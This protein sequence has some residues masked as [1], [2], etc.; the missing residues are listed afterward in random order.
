[1]NTVVSTSGLF[2]AESQYLPVVISSP[3]VILRATDELP[4]SWDNVV[5]PVDKPAGWTSFDIIRRLR[6][7]TRLRRIGH[8]GT[9]DPMATG[10]LICL[11]GK[12]TRQMTKWLEAPKT[13]TGAMRLGETTASYD[14]DTEVLETRDWRHITSEDLERAKSQ[15]IGEIVQLP[16]MYSAVKVGGERLYKKARRG[17]SIERPPRHVS[18]YSFDITDVRGQDVSFVIRCSKGTYIRS[19]AHDFGQR[20][21]VGAHL[22]ALRRTAIGDLDVRDAW[23][24]D[25]LER[26]LPS[27]DSPGPS[28]R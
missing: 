9:L 1:M 19:L 23:T 7:L 11:L 24:I 13:Y 4:G 8:A 15:F 6:K 12:A 2:P 17:E 25:A 5:L 18:V 28:D 20:L 26:V 10:L 3:D 16:P 21:G 27:A 22:V 14:A